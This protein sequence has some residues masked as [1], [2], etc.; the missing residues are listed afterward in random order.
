MDVSVK[1]KPINIKTSKPVQKPS[2]TVK[3]N[4]DKYNADRISVTEDNQVFDGGEF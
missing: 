3:T 2:I 1:L 4:N